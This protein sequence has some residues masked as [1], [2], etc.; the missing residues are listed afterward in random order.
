MATWELLG[1][2]V[3]EAINKQHCCARVARSIKLH[4]LLKAAVAVA[5]AA[6]CL[7]FHCSVLARCANLLATAYQHHA[8]A[9]CITV[10]KLPTC[11]FVDSQLAAAVLYG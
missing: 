3:L 9:L 10:M 11:S 7:P 2:L 5:S 1:R 4:G 6:R 8:A